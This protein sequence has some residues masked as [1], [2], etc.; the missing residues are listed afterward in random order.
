FVILKPEN[1]W[2]SAASKEELIVK[3]KEKISV[4]PGVNFEFTQ[5]IEMRFNELLS[6]VREDIAV[7]LFGEDLDTLA[8]KAAEMGSIIATVDGVADMRV[9]ATTDRP[10]MTVVY[11]RAK[12]AQYGQIGRAS[13]RERV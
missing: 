13:C 11:D 9:E 10:Q 2:V 3:I 6:G 4:I 8:A 7:K 12:V 5:P 1:E